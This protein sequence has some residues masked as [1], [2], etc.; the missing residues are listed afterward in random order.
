MCDFGGVFHTTSV[1]LDCA[2][3][4]VMADAMS[5]CGLHQASVWVA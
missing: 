3:L 2:G 1:A 5:S 4:T